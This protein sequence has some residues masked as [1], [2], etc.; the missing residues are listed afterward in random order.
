MRTVT[1]P[2]LVRMVWVVIVFRKMPA[3]GESSFY[4]S[5]LSQMWSRPLNV[6]LEKLLSGN[7]D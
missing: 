5:R 7:W 6:T 4:N 2:S 3:E 1:L